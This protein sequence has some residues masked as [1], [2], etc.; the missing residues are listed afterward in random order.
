MQWLEVHVFGL[1]VPEVGVP[2]VAV[3]KSES[4]VRV[5]DGSLG[6]RGS[7]TLGAMRG[8]RSTVFELRA[9]KVWGLWQAGGESNQQGRETD[10]ERGLDTRA[11]KTLGVM[12]ATFKKV[13]NYNYT[14]RV[15]KIQITISLEPMVRFACRL[16]R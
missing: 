6:T 2:L 14:I 1:R 7:K 15:S 4:Q 5:T 3:V 12:T 16:H 11:A 9:S 8:L 13:G 10:R